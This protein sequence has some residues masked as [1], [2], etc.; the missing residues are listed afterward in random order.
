MVT[1]FFHHI[2]TGVI[3]MI[4]KNERFSINTGIINV[5]FITL[6]FGLAICN[7]QNLLN[8][9]QKIVI[10][11]KNDRLFVS[12]Y[13]TG[14]LIQINKDGV[15]SK[16]LESRGF[17]DGIEIIDD[18]IY[19]IGFVSSII[20]Y[21]LNSKQL[22]KNIFIKESNGHYLSSVVSDSSGHILFSCPNLNT[23]F[24]MDIKTYKYWVYAKDNGLN[25]PNGMLL[26]RDKNRILVIDDSEAP[27]KIHAINLTDSTIKTL[28][29]NNLRRPDGI[30]KDKSG[31][32]YIGG[33]FLDGLYKYDPEFGKPP[34]L[35]FPGY[36]FVYPTFD[37]RK[38]SILVTVYDGNDWKKIELI[39]GIEKM[40]LIPGSFQLKQN[41]PNPFNPS[42][43]IEV[44]A[45]KKD[46]YSLAVFN[47]N[48]E[49]V[50]GL[51]AGILDIGTHKF[52]FCEPALASGIYF[53][54]FSN[55][56]ESITHK[57]VLIK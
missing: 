56:A 27:S 45:N 43:T 22:V 6:I 40:G 33:Y 49:K 36:T 42:T 23:I 1:R 34:V 2:H 26:E 16:F 53:Y 10:D 14:D 18:Y 11:S 20:I 50:T 12:N 57:M 21:D 39:T 9:P 47:T 35:F 19:G 29:S 28:A 8:A 32:Y 5:L 38:N 17:V 41:Y 15:Q 25:K 30:I 46:Y 4:F 13:N 3:L 55:K 52:N 48:G 54:R 37:S 44:L 51:F 24:K 31:N 7:A